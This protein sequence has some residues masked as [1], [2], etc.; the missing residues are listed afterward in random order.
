VIYD[1][2]ST[3]HRQLVNDFE[4]VVGDVNDTQKL[5]ELLPGISGI[6]H[7][8]AHAYV[9]ESVR[10]PRKYFD[11]NVIGGLAFLNAALDAGVKHIVFSSTCAVYGI[12]S[13]VPIHES[14]PRNPINAYGMSKLFMENALSAY[15]SAYGI[16]SVCLRYF[17]AAGADEDGG[18]G[19]IHSPETHLIPLAISAAMG[20]GPPLHIYGGDY[21]TLD[22]T[23]VRD[24]V[25]V[26]DLAEAHVLALKYLLD[27]GSTISVNLGTGEGH[28]I[29]H[30]L[31]R[32]QELTGK[33]VP[34][35]VVARRSGDPPTLVSDPSLA[36]KVLRWR[37]CRSLH[38]IIATA[39]KWSEYLN[40]GNL[41][42]SLNDGRDVNT[43][44]C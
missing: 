14:V 7:F 39:W 20:F 30:L 44:G 26:S 38:T 37:A 13:K 25:H 42:Y 15:D 17:N 3:G 18:I 43:H 5:S 33:E 34:C 2:L 32:I 36:N 31:A 1:N 19:E 23:C 4:L 40:A 8:A 35:E 41:D 29:R 11:N 12:P 28:S 21:P 22:G 9:G 6:I 10:H 27:G 24:Y 16:R